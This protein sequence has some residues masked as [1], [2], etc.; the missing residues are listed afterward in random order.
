MVKVAFVCVENAGR[1]QMA[2]AFARRL[3]GS[4]VE[5]IGGGTRPAEAVYPA[6]A[7]AMKEVS[8]DI[9]GNKPRL[10]TPSE[11]ADCDYVITMGCSSDEVCP[12]TFRGDARD[13]DLPDPRGKSLPEVRRIR[14]DIEKKV[15]MLIREIGNR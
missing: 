5:V 4:G 6:V 10:I 13:W 8:L 15:E 1:S 3:A 2:A 9:A 7:E 12:V 14:D 11:L